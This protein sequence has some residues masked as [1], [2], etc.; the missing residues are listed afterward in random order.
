MRAARRQSGR[1]AAIVVASLSTLACSSDTPRPSHLL[2]GS[3][4]GRAPVPLDGAGGPAILTLARAASP[5]TLARCAAARAPG[6]RVL[7]RVG[8]GAASVTVLDETGREARACDA[9]A[10]DGHP[11]ATA[12][13]RLRRG[14]L[15]DS[16]LTVTCET[17]AGPRAFAWMEPGSAT[18]YVSVDRGGWVEVYPVAGDLPVRITSDD[19]DLAGRARFRI[20]EH[21][22]RGR[23]IAAYS[24]EPRVAG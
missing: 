12:L 7:E 11:C 2:D 20:A 24:L 17:T 1:L 4:A 5:A 3:P 16:R 10:P 21:D 14:R 19:V 18:R 13:G 8:V 6:A 15:E 23:R 9:V 22:R